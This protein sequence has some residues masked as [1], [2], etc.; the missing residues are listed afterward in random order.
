[1]NTF[2]VKVFQINVDFFL[3]K[4]KYLIRLFLIIVLISLEIVKNW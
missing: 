3:S 2:I 1:M 4:S